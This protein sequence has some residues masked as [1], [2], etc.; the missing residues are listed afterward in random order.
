MKSLAF[1]PLSPRL[2]GLRFELRISEESL[3]TGVGGAI[4]RALLMLS[5]SGGLPLSGR[6][7]T[8]CF[9]QGLSFKAP[10]I[11]ETAGMFT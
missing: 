3:V 7:A 9:A 6:G 1:A 8:V 11:G 5:N 2:N 4:D 10:A